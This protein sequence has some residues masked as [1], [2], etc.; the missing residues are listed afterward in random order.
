MTDDAVVAWKGNTLLTFDGTV[1]EVFGYPGT[2]SARFHVAN[3]DLTVGEP[4]RK[5]DRFLRLATRLRSAGSMRLEVT[6]DEW[7]EVQE[8]IDAVQAALALD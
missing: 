8:V 5:G 7:L 2:L 3:L 6:A 1:L 4:D